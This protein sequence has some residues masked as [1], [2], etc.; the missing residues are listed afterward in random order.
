MRKF[1]RRG[2]GV[3]EDDSVGDCAHLFC[4]PDAATPSR[5]SISAGSSF[6]STLSVS[7]IFDLMRAGVTDLGRMMM[8]FFTERMYIRIRV[9]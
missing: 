5:R 2:A 4:F 1:K 9:D 3:R 8:S 6:G 7:V